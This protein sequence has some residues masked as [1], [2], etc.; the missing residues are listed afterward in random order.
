M[1]YGCYWFQL[2]FS[3]IKWYKITHP[4]Y[5]SNEGLA[6]LL[7]LR[8]ACVVTF[9]MSW[10]HHAVKQS[11][12]LFYPTESEHYGKSFH[13]M[14]HHEHTKKPLAQ[15]DKF[16]G[17][18]SFELRQRLGK[19][20]ISYPGHS[21]N[22]GYQITCYPCGAGN[23]TSFTNPRMHLFRIPQCSIQ[24]RNV[25]ISFLNRALWD[26]EQVHSGICEIGLLCHINLSWRR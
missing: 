3:L 20:Q 9:T 17:L 25:H 8:H 23:K 6:E 22:M 19:A 14:F 1:L 24:N 5:Y 4:C 16:P 11:C 10:R 18:T 7:S 12:Q 21:N 13:E 15:M 2:S 26:M